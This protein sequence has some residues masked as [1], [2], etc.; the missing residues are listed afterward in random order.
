LPRALT[1][2]S[3]TFGLMPNAELMYRH[4]TK[5]DRLLG[6]SFYWTMIASAVVTVAWVVVVA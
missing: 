4:T 1:R 6:R 2:R 3:G 5:L